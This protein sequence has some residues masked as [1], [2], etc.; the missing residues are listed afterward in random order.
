MKGKLK[1]AR[2]ELLSICDICGR[3]RSVKVHTRCSKIRQERHAQALRDQAFDTLLM[4]GG[5]SV[6]YFPG[7]PLVGEE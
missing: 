2:P 7:E 1:H 3:A 5:S 6:K 4:R